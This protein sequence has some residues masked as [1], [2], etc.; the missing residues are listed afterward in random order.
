MCVPLSVLLGSASASRSEFR[1]PRPN[2]RVKQKPTASYGRAKNPFRAWDRQLLVLRLQ[3]QLVITVRRDVGRRRVPH[4]IL[5]PQILPDLRKDL[6]QARSLR[7]LEHP[8]ARGSPKNSAKPTARYRIPVD[9]HPPVRAH[10]KESSRSARLRAAP[11]R[12]PRPANC[13]FR[14]RPHRS[15]SQSPCAPSPSPARFSRQPPPASFSSVPPRVAACELNPSSARCNVFG[16]FVSPCNC[17][18]LVSNCTSIARSCSRPSIVWKNTSLASDSSPRNVL[19][20]P[21]VSTSSARVN[22]SSDPCEKYRIGISRPSCFSTKSFLG[23]PARRIARLTLHHRRDLDHPRL[24]PQRRYLFRSTLRPRP[25]RRDQKRGTHHPAPLPHRVNPL[26]VSLDPPSRT[27]GAGPTPDS[28]SPRITW[29]PERSSTNSLG[30]TKPLL[31]PARRGRP[32]EMHVPTVD[33][34]LLPRRMR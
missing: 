19:W 8:P 1:E 14:Y 22:G 23:Q 21:L 13:G 28:L 32:I 27:C 5:Q 18:T 9:H 24:H 11:V 4:L 33:E 6:P 34:H 31:R 15:V 7:H 16:E 29:Q 2:L 3:L 25:T 17:C 30:R 10:C 26:R 12:S 20:L